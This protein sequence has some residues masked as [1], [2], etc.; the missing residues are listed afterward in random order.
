MV[1]V[2]YV[3]C[4]FPTTGL[5]TSI[6]AMPQP[7]VVIVT[8]FNYVL[9]NWCVYCSCISVSPVHLLRIMHSS[10][11][12]LLYRFTRPYSAH[13]PTIGLDHVRAATGMRQGLTK[14]RQHT[15]AKMLLQ[16]RLAVPLCRR[17]YSERTA[18][19]HPIVWDKTSWENCRIYHFRLYINGFR[20]HKR[21]IEFWS[22]WSDD[23]STR[24]SLDHRRTDFRC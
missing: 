6:Y 22:R 20:S 12:I 18:R 21:Q 15:L 10:E 8:S 9:I 17:S 11:F 19:F 3:L 7:H 24:T 2:C 5:Y 13:S 1:R 4:V 14:Q 16:F 23:V